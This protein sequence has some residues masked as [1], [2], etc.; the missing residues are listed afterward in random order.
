MVSVVEDMGSWELLV[1]GLFVKHI[2][3]V[4]P[5]F[6]ALDRIETSLVHAENIRNL[7][8][9]ASYEKRFLVVL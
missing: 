4:I 6:S 3:S 1:V 5:E 2:S 9:I 7:P 8:F